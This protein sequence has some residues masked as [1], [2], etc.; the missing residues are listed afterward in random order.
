M[1]LSITAVVAKSQ[2]GSQREV[3][4]AQVDAP[5]YDTRLGTYAELDQAAWRSMCY[6]E[7]LPLL[8]AALAD[9]RGADDLAARAAASQALSRLVAA[10]AAAAAAAEDGDGGP[11]GDGLSILAENGVVDAAAAA[12]DATGG[13]IVAL[14]ERVLY[15]QLKRTL[16]S[17]SLAVRQVNDLF[18]PALLSLMRC[19]VDVPKMLHVLVLRPHPK[20]C[21]SSVWRNSLLTDELSVMFAGARGSSEAAGA[22]VPCALPGLASAV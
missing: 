12:A 14:A 2:I 20:S 10:A 22:G 4:L 16:A 19:S 1:Y 5:D 9:L 18:F 6:V 7:A 15:S 3:C 8:H 11:A 17:P 21:L 13:R